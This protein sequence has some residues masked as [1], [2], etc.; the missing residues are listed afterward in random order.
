MAKRQFCRESKRCESPKILLSS[1]RTGVLSAETIFS[2]GKVYREAVFLFI[3]L[4]IIGKK[5]Q[6]PLDIQNR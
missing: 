5:M 2:Q 3:R 6:M 1:R 4:A